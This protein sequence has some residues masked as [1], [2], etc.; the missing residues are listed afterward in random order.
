VY[1]DK[2]DIYI[3]LHTR[4]LFINSWDMYDQLL[5]VHSAIVVGICTNWK[6][7]FSRGIMLT[8][9]ISPV[10]EQWVIFIWIHNPIWKLFFITV[11][12]LSTFTALPPS[13]E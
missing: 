12:L 10:V 2:V 8:V 13:L 9:I 3:D 4:F 5:S 11:F 6:R 7:I 1:A